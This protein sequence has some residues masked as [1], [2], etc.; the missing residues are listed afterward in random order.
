MS[1][2]RAQQTKEQTH[3]EPDYGPET[4]TWEDRGYAAPICR[5]G[6]ERDDHGSRTE[7]RDGQKVYVQKCEHCPCETFLDKDGPMSKLIDSFQPVNR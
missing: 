4:D 6:H 3:M 5:C 2:Q 7:Q 1:P